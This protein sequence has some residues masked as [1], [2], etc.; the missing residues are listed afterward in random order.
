VLLGGTGML[1]ERT[2]RKP[3]NLAYRGAAVAIGVAAIVLGEADDAPG[4]VLFGGLLIAGTVAL[5]FRTAQRS[6]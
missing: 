5:A 6:E 4:L 2:A 1:I 3:G